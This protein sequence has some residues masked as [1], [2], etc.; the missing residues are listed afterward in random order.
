M[1]FKNSLH[2]Y[3]HIYQY[4]IYDNYMSINNTYY[5]MLFIRF[6]FESHTE[7]DNVRPYKKKILANKGKFSK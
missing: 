3:F 5:K 2:L 1:Y 4:Y 6:G 7:N